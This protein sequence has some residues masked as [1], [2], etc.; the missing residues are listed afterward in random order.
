MRTTSRILVI[1]KEQLPG[2]KELPTKV[3]QKTSREWLEFQH[4]STIP[5]NG[6]SLLVALGLS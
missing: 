1:G 5:S 6:I 4:I 2:D 3:S